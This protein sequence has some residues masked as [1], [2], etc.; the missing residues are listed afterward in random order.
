MSWLTVST[1][2]VTA[3][4]VYFVGLAE[5]EKPKVKNCAP[6]WKLSVTNEPDERVNVSVAASALIV[7]PVPVSAVEV[8]SPG[9]GFTSVSKM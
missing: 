8:V 1:R 5:L 3:A 4:I 6:T 7:W 9:N 2:S